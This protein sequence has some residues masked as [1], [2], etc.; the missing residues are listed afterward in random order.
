MP[1][2]LPQDVTL[3]GELYIGR[4]RFD[5]TSGLVRTTRADVDTDRRWESIKYMVRGGDAKICAYETRTH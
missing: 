5:E 3:D 4:D 2:E 1:T